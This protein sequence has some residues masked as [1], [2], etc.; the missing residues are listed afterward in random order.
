APDR[1][2]L[3]LRQRYND[4]IPPLTPEHLKLL[5]DWPARLQSTTDDTT[6]YEV[7]RKQLKDDNYRESLSPQKAPKNAAPPDQPWGERL[8]LPGKERL[9]GSYPYRGGVSPYRRTGE[10]PIRM[11]AGEGTPERTIRRFH[12]LSVGQPAARLSTAFD[13]VTLYGEDPAPR[14]DIYGKIGNS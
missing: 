10:D 14:P 13:S 5:P 1:S 9:P 2:L 4:A 7:R 3:T 11:F 6:A 8:T 12:Y